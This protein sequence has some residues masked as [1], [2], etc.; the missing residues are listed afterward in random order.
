MNRAV[1]IEN[2]ALFYKCSGAGTQFHEVDNSVLT[3]LLAV[4]S[5]WFEL[6][7][8]RKDDAFRNANGIEATIESF[9]TG[10]KPFDLYDACVIEGNEALIFGDQRVFIQLVWMCS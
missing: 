3:A 9:V 6:G 8:K 4:I 1:V 7:R 10:V 2:E 5:D